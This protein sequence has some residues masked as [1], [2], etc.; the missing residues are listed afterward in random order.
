[1]DE[2]KVTID[3][4]GRQRHEAKRKY[5]GRSA[6]RQ[7]IFG[8][9]RGLGALALGNF[10]NSAAWGAFYAI[11]IFYLYTPFTRGLGFSQGDA[12][13]LISAMGAANAL[14]VIVGSWLSDRVL[15]MRKALIIGNLLKALAFFLLAIPPATQAS[16][17]VLAFIA[18][19]LLSIPI[20]GASN[21]SL[22]G[23]LYDKDDNQRRDAAFTVHQFANTA[24]GILIPVLVAQLG[25]KNYH[26]GFTVAGIFA[27]LYGATIFFTQYRF[28][29]PLG[30]KPTMPLK[31]EEWKKVG[32]IS[33]VIVA[34]A[35]GIVGGLI[36][37]E[38]LSLHG[39]IN[40]ITTCTFLIPILFLAHLFLKKDL[41][42]VD[43]RH[44]RPFMAFFLAQIIVALGGNML[45]S[46]VAIFIDQKLERQ[47]FGFTIAPGSVPIIYT[48][49]SLIASPIFIY[50]WTKMKSDKLQTVGKY[51][52]GLIISALAFFTLA[53]PTVLIGG[54]G[55][56]SMWWIV[57]YYIFMSVSDQL[58]WPIGSSMVSRLSPKA[59]QTQMQTAFGQTAA[60]GNGIALILFQFFKTADQQV[61]LFPIMAGV[62][63]L[64]ALILLAF[65]KKIE[66]QMAE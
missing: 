47:F 46:A 61:Y 2:G 39:F 43:R 12:A 9:P 22:T 31:P 32:F 30:E 16:G 56:F 64:V 63:A 65:W 34:V 66:S 54:G 51:G 10:C 6:K 15:G 1:M 5:I 49:L 23:Q 36:A 52:L 62:L 29:G 26:I 8:H 20:M 25:M 24:A 17:Q 41:T 13:L 33:I 59:Y 45:T 3:L 7:K 48:I 55:R 50:L 60:I 57:V 53:I 4:G 58:I 19:I 44:F 28:F 14:L 27:L 37:A 38:K 18:L 21:P 40:I 35:G 11:M 42:R